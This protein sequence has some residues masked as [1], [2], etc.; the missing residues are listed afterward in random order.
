LNTNRKLRWAIAAVLGASAAGTNLVFA[1]DATE[2][3]TSGIQEIVVTAQRRNESIQDVPITIQALTTEQLAQL[4]VATFDDLL[5]YTP[6]VTYASNGPG[7]GQIYMRGLAA[8]NAGNQSAATTAPFPN[9]A[10]Y[11][12][13]QSMQF[14]G[15]NV[16]V[17]M[18]D[19]ERVE[20]LEGPQGTLF[21]GGAEAGAIRYITNK[22]KLDVTEGNVNV[23]YG[24]TAGGDPNAS[25]VATL[26]LPIVPGVLAVRATVFDDR[27]GGY[28]NNVPGTFTLPAAA[29]AT[30]VGNPT[31]NNNS[32]V[33][34]ATNP[35]TYTGFR[36]GALWQ[37]N[38][39]WNLL[40]TQSYQNMEADGYFADYPISS[41]GQT[42]GSDEITAFQP[43]YD[44]DHFEN[45]A[46]TVNG[47]IDD[48][49]LVYTGSYLDRHIQQQQDY[50][51]YLKTGGGLYYACTGGALNSGNLGANT[52]TK[53]Y[54]SSQALTCYTPNGSWNDTVENTHQ[55]HEIRVSTPDDKDVRGIIGLYYEKFVIDDQMNF[56]YLDIPQCTTTNYSIAVGGGPACV[57]AVGPVPG[58]PAVDPGLRS[59]NTAFGE[60]AQRGY[61]QFAFF[62]S[63]DY[64]IIPKVLT[65]SGGTRHYDYSEFETGSEFYTST[66]CVDVPNGGCTG[67][68]INKRISYSGWRSRGNLSWHVTPDILVYYTWSQGFR[69]GA[70][71]RTEGGVADYLATA[72]AAGSKEPQFEKPSGYG[73]DK[74]INNEIGLKS[75]WLDHRLQVNISGYIMDWKDVQLSFFNPVALGNTTFGVNGPDYKIKGVELQ[76]VARITDGLSVQGSSSWNSAN[77]TS[78]P[79]L[80]SNY[81]GDGTAANPASPTL[82]QCISSVKGAPFEN[83]FG[84]LDTRPAY[85]PPLQFNLRARYD[86]T[87]LDYKSF[88]WVGA[89]HTAHM[90]NEPATYQSGNAPNEAIPTTTL[91]RYDMPA[92]TTYDAA[93]AVAKDNWNVQISGSNLTNSDASTFTSSA[94]FIKSEVPLRPRVLT[95]GFGYKF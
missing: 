67:S 78:S 93:I 68:P 86:W 8:T 83:P 65:I 64:D 31:I 89:S 79:C 74:L 7:A 90:Y 92:Y 44:K 18:A 33:A 29:G 48:F 91:L 2:A 32:L 81:V 21:G 87:W 42:L 59:S 16:D 85:S 56:N 39:N 12:D 30:L 80:I 49:K 43:A 73:P 84:A 82:G 66:G 61:S 28:I 62:G 69:P 15:R 4:N 23:T 25:G 24:T 34:D 95:L 76:A 9:V 45:T 26:N 52:T 46:W 41:N 53:T 13:D 19:M 88:A 38:E 77:Q 51:N 3:D 22:P 6:N 14:P 58:T 63:A 50:T 54:P 60:D 75:E 27:R 70:F 36:L 72:N 57:S 35:V 1:A 11:L 94:Q 47:K 55:S 40:V 37:I 17:Y 20:V 71:N 10:V 5:K